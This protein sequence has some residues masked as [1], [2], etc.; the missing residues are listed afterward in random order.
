M[1]FQMKSHHQNPHCKRCV[2]EAS[3]KPVRAYFPA[4]LLLFFALS[5]QAQNQ[6]PTEAEID[7]ELPIPSSDFVPPPP[8][9]EVPR[10][11]VEATASRDMGTHRIT[12]LR[13]E[14][15]TLPDI[16]PPPEPK[17]FIPVPAG[18]PQYLLSFGTTVYDHRLSHVTWYDP[19]SKQ[20]FEAWCAWDWTLLCPLPRI[21]QANQMGAF[22]LFASNINTGRH[23]RFGKEFV[24]PEHPMLE[25]LAFSITKGDP[26]N[27]D[28]NRI[29]T[30]L[31][32]YY[33]RHKDRLL[34]IR[35]AREDYQKNS[36]AWHAANPPKPENHTYWLKPHRGS[37]YLKPEGQAR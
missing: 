33:T 34:A 7:K 12:I 9:K 27:A 35:E 28:A 6:V 20:H 13:G 24:M 30:D 14:A 19:R 17:P 3:L 10:M 23:L 18:E 26:D 4:A 16:P 29:L 11:E 15:S 8:P 37:R 36:D 1:R 22:S 2:S 25:D 31:R 5:L 21:N 32:D